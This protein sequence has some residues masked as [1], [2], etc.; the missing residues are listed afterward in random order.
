[1]A[2]MDDASPPPEMLDATGATP[3]MQQYFDAKAKQ[4]DALVFFRMGDFY[5]L[6]FEDAVAAA[7]ALDV[8]LTKR[9]R[10]A[11]AD[12]PMCGVPVH[13]AE[14]YLHPPIPTRFRVATC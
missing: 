9:G 12:I 6:F 8:A 1:M 5:E 7:P 11:G 3:V 2:A 14:L 4:P 10:H 13:A